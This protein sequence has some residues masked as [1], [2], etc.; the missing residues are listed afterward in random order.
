MMEPYERDPTAIYRRSFQIIRH[1]A[2]ASLGS[3][4]SD[5]EPLAVRLMHAVGQIDLV[6]DLRFSSAAIA[7][8]VAAMRAGAPILVDAQMVAGGITKRFLSDEASGRSNEVIVT[9]ND[10]KIPPL[11]K[12]METTRSAAALELWRP[13]P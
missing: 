5:I 13:P 9:L 6:T 11:A 10:P 3:L 2:S 4:P 1:E 12:E 8:G 7:S